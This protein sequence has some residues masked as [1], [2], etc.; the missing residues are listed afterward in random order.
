M[1]NIKPLKPFRFWAQK[2]IPLVYEESLSY[3]ELL[4][5]VIDYLNTMGVDFNELLENFIEFD[6]DMTG[7]FNNLS[8]EFR[9]LKTWAEQEFPEFVNDKLDEMAEDGTL[10]ALIAP[11]L[12]FITP[13]MFGAVG[14]GIADDTEAVEKALSYANVFLSKQYKVSGC[15]S[16]ARNVFGNGEIIYSDDYGIVC[17]SE[18]ATFDGIKLTSSRLKDGCGIQLN[19]GRCVIR[20]CEF[21]HGSMGIYSPFSPDNTVTIT[22]ILVENCY[23]HDL[24]RNSIVDDPL[25]VAGICLYT[26]VNSSIKNCKLENIQ[27]DADADCDAIRVALP[28]SLTNIGGTITIENCDIVNVKGRGIKMQGSN[29]VISEC[30]IKNDD[31]SPLITNFH[32]IDIQHGTGKIIGCVIGASLSGGTQ[33]AI[34]VT[35]HAEKDEIVEISSCYIDVKSN[36]HCITT[37]ITPGVANY[38][39]Q[40]VLHDN[41]LISEKQSLY[42]TAIMTYIIYNNFIKVTTASTSYVYMNVAGR[43]ITDNNKFLSV[44]YAYLSGKIAANTKCKDFPIVCQTALTWSDLVADTRFLGNISDIS[45]LNG[46]Y[47]IETIPMYQGNFVVKVISNIDYKVKYYASDG[48]ALT[49]N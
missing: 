44:N 11:Y 17:D 18:G 13:E 12:P 27:T 34:N 39:Y 29:F 41:V 48:T 33:S 4:C 8:D 40:L 15:N 35:I 10:T 43:L 19:Y 9:D 32:G 16:T 1:N 42:F 23:I 3:Y 7:K 31:D 22:D 47:L 2:V 28:H 24:D 20:N 5:K 30:R 25:G 37:S 46:N 49:N 14:D 6:E 38:N 36:G 45:D 26:A 21:E